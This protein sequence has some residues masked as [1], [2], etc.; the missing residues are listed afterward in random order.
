MNTHETTD[1]RDYA[2]RL[3]VEAMVRAGEAEQEIEAA[4]REAQEERSK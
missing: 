3:L 4:L 2:L 1:V